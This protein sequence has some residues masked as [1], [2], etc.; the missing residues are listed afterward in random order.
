M[1]EPQVNALTRSVQV[2]GVVDNAGHRI[3]PGMLLNVSLS[4][5]VAE[6]TVVPEAAL[7][8]LGEKQFLFTVPEGSDKVARAEVKLGRRV[9]RWA[10]VTEGVARGVRIVTEGI[11]VV[12]DGQRVVVG[13]RLPAQ[14]GKA[15]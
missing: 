3:K 7:V 12:S 13:E 15:E 4:T 8:S 10:E 9:G 14:E 1:V 6:V 2:R 11:S 5:G